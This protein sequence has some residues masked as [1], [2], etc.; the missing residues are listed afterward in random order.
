MRLLGSPFTKATASE[1]KRPKPPNSTPLT[2]VAAYLPS[3]FSPASSD[4]QIA[5]M[6]P[7]MLAL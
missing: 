1:A 3:L 6:G 2:T 5:V 7:A 4:E